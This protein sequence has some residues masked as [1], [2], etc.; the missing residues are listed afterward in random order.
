LAVSPSRS[1]TRRGFPAEHFDFIVI[2]ECHRSIYNVWR[3]VIE[4]FDAF[5]IGV[6]ATPTPQT[7]RFFRSNVVQA[8]SH[9]KAAVDRINGQVLRD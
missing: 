6:I 1:S 2:D 9:A 8:Y 3:H 5:L 7:I 4:C